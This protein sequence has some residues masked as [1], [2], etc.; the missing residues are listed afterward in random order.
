MVPG[1]PEHSLH[2]SDRDVRDLELCSPS[3]LGVASRHHGQDLPP[4][5]L[6]L[7]QA[8]QLHELATR[9]TDR[10]RVGTRM[11]QVALDG[12]DGLGIPA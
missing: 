5:R 9:R 12:L 3:Q 2:S 1:I 10:K 7:G 4:R 6:A 11:L 8:P